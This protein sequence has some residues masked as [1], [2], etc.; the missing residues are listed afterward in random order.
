MSEPFIGEIR[1]VGFNFAPRGWALCDGQLLAI[2]QNTALF[3]LLGT[4]YGGDGRTTFGLPDLRSRVPMHAGTGPG[5]TPRQLGAKFGLETVT[6]NVSQLPAHT[7]AAQ[8]SSGSGNANSPIGR[9]WSKDAGVQS[10]TYTGNAPDGSMAA[11]AIGNAGGGQAHDN[12][13][14]VQVVNF[15]IALVGL[16][17]SRN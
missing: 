4:I 13:P 1:M 17:P 9:I 14:P 16:F 12:M 10:A 6:L 15:V 8:A 3:S 2:A 11:N 7:H 5:L